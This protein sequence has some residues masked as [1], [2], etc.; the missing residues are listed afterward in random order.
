MIVLQ[1]IHRCTVTLSSLRTIFSKPRPGILLVLIP[2]EYVPT[3]DNIPIVLKTFTIKN[4]YYVANFEF[5]YLI[6]RGGRIVSR[7]DCQKTLDWN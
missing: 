2:Q 5:M 3:L 6:R 4:G 1:W 7:A